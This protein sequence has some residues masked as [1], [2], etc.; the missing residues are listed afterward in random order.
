MRATVQ[1]VL[2]ET[3]GKRDAATYTIGDAT[4]GMSGVAMQ[5]PH[6]SLPGPEG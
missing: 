1:Q 6:R 4:L 3:M 5:G 2:R